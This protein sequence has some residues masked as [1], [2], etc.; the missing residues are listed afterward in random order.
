MTLQNRLAETTDFIHQKGVDAVEFGLILGSGLGELAE[1]IEDKIVIPYAE[2]PH[3]PVSTVVGHAGQLVYG[4]LAGKKVLAMQGRFHF[5]EGHSM[6]VVTYPVR[7]M[8]ALKAHSLIV[9]NACGGV[10]EAF[11]PGDLMLITDHINFMGTNPLIGKNEDEIGPR[12]PDMSQAYHL[13]YRNVAKQVA[14]EKGLHLKEGVYMGFTGPTYETPAE[15][16]FARTIGADAV[17]MSTV[18]EVIVAVHSGLKVLGIS[19]ITNLA[20]GMQA[21]LNHEEVV[22]TTER[23][24]AEFKALVKETLAAL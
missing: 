16:R 21:N 19:C 11:A 10:N 3:F 9:T 8:S 20:A 12:F 14:E 15:I 4:T 13:D 1:E 24:K 22:E 23:V 17:G 5:Y 7:V 18:P 2:I 6:Q